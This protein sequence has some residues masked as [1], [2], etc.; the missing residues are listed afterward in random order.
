MSKD[1]ILWINTG[2][3]LVSEP[4]DDPYD[5]PGKVKPLDPSISGPL[6]YS[7]LA[8]LNGHHD[9]VDGYSYGIHDRLGEALK[10]FQKDSK[11]FGD[12]DIKALADII[13]ADT[14]HTNILITHGTDQMAINAEKLKIALGDT[15]KKIIF[16]GSMLPLSMQKKFEGLGDIEEN[17]E[18]A[19][20]AFDTLKKGVYV[21][22][23]NS[24]T[25]RMQCMAPE[26]V[27]K[28]TIE[29]KRDLHFT[30]KGRTPGWR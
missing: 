17:I 14:D 21:A 23:R 20:G 28:D 7:L 11:D 29:S 6:V 3:T 5:P 8:K 4:Y 30:L 26:T 24:E 12:D 16:T 19:L 9:K 13:R 2:G 15:D 18:F 10:A 1:R 25:M 27:E 22:G